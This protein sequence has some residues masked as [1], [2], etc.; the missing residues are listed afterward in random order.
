MTLR[1]RCIRCGVLA[2]LDPTDIDPGACAACRAKFWGM[3]HIGESY[4]RRA[5]LW[6]RHLKHRDTHPTYNALAAALEAMES[7]PHG[8]LDAPL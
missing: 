2:D 8:G 5:A 7:V 1:L 6:F 4:P 3:A